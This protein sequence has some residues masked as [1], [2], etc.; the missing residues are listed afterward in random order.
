MRIPKQFTHKGKVWKVEY[1]EELHHEDGT[2]CDGLCDWDSRTI[3]LDTSLTGKKKLAIFL[4]ELFHVLVWEA[5][6]SEG[7][8]FTED[9]EDILADAFSDMLTTTFG[10]RPGK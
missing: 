9:I 3:F 2:E 10:V 1:E 5:H 8:A 4:H 6:I 7:A